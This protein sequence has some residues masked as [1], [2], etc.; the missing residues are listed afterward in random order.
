MKNWLKVAKGRNGSGSL[1]H[2]FE[3]LNIDNFPGLFFSGTANISYE[4]TYD[5]GSSYGPP[6]NS[7]PPEFDI[8]M[9]E[10][11]V[12]APTVKAF[13]EN[14]NETLVPNGAIKQIELELC[15]NDEINDKIIEKS[16]G[17]DSDDGDDY[18]GDDDYSK[19]D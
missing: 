15:N 8:G 7:Y 13:D 14:G 17:W 5:P 2:E 18:N 10:A 4:F 6:E 1:N 12:E 11:T 16:R 3:E 19:Y 9:I